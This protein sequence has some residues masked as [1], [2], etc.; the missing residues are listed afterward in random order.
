MRTNVAKH[1]GFESL[2]DVQ[3]EIVGVNRCNKF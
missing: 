2:I 3:S 1:D